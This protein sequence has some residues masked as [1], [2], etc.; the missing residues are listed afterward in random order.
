MSRRHFTSTL[1]GTL[2]ALWAAA[3]TVPIAGNDRNARINGFVFGEG[4]AALANVT[5]TTVDGEKVISTTTDS[6]GAYRL[7]YSAAP[8]RM[9]I[10]INDRAGTIGDAGTIAGGAGF[11]PSKLVLEYRGGVYHYPG[12]VTLVRPTP[13]SPGMETTLALGGKMFKVK[14]PAGVAPDGGRLEVAVF[15]P[16]AGPAAFETTEDVSQKLQSSGLFFVRA[17][18]AAGRPAAMQTAAASVTFTIDNS[19][20]MLTDGQPLKIYSLETDGLWKPSTTQTAPTLEL[21]AVSEGYWLAGRAYKTACVRGRFSAPTK[22]CAG[23]I[24]RISG[25]DSLSTFD[26][27]GIG[28]TFC[29]EA[30]QGRNQVMTIGTRS[31]PVSFPSKPGSC[32]VDPNECT[33]LSAIAVADV[34]CPTSCTKSQVDDPSGCGL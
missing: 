21:Q 8:D 13:L 6:T 3:C 12:T 7:A 15:P 25:N 5:V 20:P 34:D 17:V 32:H 31:Q 18:D 28:G 22:A 16:E 2:V 14:A 27:T 9:V 10:S 4:G 19:V 30:A 33:E 26:V 29:V 1:L 24:V 23:E 11:L